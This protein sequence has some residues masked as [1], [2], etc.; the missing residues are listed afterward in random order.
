M[1]ENINFDE[2]MKS[3][4]EK[5][6]KVGD[7]AVE[8]VGAVPKF[9]MRLSEAF[10]TPLIGK[11]RVGLLIS[12]LFATVLYSIFFMFSELFRNTLKVDPTLSWLS[13]FLSIGTLAIMLMTLSRSENNA[14]KGVTVLQLPIYIIM[15][16]LISIAYVAANSTV[17]TVGDDIVKL[18]RAIAGAI[19]SINI[20]PAITMLYAYNSKKH[21]RTMTEA[22]GSYMSMVVKVPTFAWA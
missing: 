14:L 19:L 17:V 2:R 1:N 9:T 11:D 18:G 12:A 4:K 20:V 7:I 22:A 10:V 16:T 21:F 8:A 3:I 15:V 6:S 13:G 5:A